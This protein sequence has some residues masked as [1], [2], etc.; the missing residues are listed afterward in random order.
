MAALSGPHLQSFEGAETKLLQHHVA[1]PILIFAKS[2]QNSRNAASISRNR[3][4]IVR[5][6]A[7]FEG[8]EAIKPVNK[9]RTLSNTAF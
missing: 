6:D 7:E 2:R 1:A 8:S 4:P 3:T 5:N 9:S